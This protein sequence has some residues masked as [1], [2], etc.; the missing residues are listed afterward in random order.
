M[1]T[2]LETLQGGT[3]YLEKRG[4][5][6]ARLNMQLLLAAELGCSKLDLYMQFDR[7]LGE[8][9]LAPLRELVKRRGAREPLQ[10]LLGEVEFAGQVFKCDARALI[11]R[12]ETEE[13]VLDLI[14]SPPLLAERDRIVDVG[15]GSGVIGLSLAHS[16]KDRG[17]DI[18]LVDQHEAPLTLA[19]ENAEALELSSSVN[20][21]QSDLLEKAPGPFKLIVANLPYVTSSEMADVSAEVL[22]DPPTAL[23]GGAD[24]LDLIRRL[25]VDAATHL[26]PGG[27]IVLE[28]GAAQ[29]DATQMLLKDGPFNEITCLTDLSGRD[30]FVKASR[31]N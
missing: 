14:K 19:K 10:H 24:G 31:T 30:R 9:E 11:P 8:D 17:L 15:T 29:A 16:W 22:H 13:L 21:V 27:N 2:V 12:P 18:V 26:S 6:D 5:A 3:A 7:P 25:I 28:I 4:V 20:F 1:K 23:D